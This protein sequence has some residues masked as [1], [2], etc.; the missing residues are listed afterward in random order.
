M[1]KY[2]VL[3]KNIN[4]TESN[5]IV[6]AGNENDA[7]WEV[8]KMEGIYEATTLGRVQPERSEAILNYFR[9]HPFINATSVAKAVGYDIGS[10]SKLINNTGRLSA[11]PNKHLNKFEKIL[12][13]YGF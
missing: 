9:T 1:K 6:E 12:K 2:N 10:L 3:A 7:R 11:I 5:L 13:D 4:G 8:K